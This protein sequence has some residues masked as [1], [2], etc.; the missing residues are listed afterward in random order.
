MKQ[1]KANMNQIFF[2]QKYYFES[3]ERRHQA[4]IERFVNFYNIILLINNLGKFT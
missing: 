1:L 2:D 3:Q 4:E